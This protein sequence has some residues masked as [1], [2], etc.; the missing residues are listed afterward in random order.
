MK[1]KY[2]KFKTDCKMNMI[3]M[4]LGDKWGEGNPEKQITEAGTTSHNPMAR[5]TW[6]IPLSAA[7]G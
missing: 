2:K 7:I 5:E 3:T 1:G 6:V 4:K